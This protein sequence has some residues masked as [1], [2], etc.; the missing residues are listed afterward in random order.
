MTHGFIIGRRKEGTRRTKVAFVTLIASY[1]DA[2]LRL[3]TKA[4]LA[5]FET[6]GLVLNGETF[7]CIAQME[8]HKFHVVHLPLEITG[9]DRHVD[10]ESS[11]DRITLNQQLREAHAH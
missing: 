9:T 5:R 3:L 11:C 1:S 7:S 10:D 4:T 8:G 6:F 2:L